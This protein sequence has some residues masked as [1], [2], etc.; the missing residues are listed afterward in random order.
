[1]TEEYLDI[2]DDTDNVIGKDTRKAVHANY[3]MHR[4]VHVFVVNCEGRILIQKRSSQKDYYPGYY[5][6]S[7]GAQVLSG[8]S[9]EEAAR[10]EL[11][12]ELGI[13]CNALEV[14]ADYDAF[15]TRQREKRRVYICK[16]D[17]PFVPCAEEVESISFMSV[18]DL[19]RALAHQPFTEGFKRSLEIYLRHLEE[20][21]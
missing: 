10:R 7:V 11:G 16:S 12:E 6:I 8:E 15:S 13:Q 17:G 20:K 9:Y 4:G 1:M 3:Q 19:Q 18:D 14:L 5:D 21:I 2:V